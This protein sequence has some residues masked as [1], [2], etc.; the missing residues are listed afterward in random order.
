MR[1]VCNKLKLYFVVGLPW[2]FVVEGQVLKKIVK[3][4]GKYKNTLHVFANAL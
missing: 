4:K 1:K 3:L 2:E